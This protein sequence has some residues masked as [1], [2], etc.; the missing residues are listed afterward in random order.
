MP[1]NIVDF[2]WSGLISSN[3]ALGNTS[4]VTGT[5]YQVLPRIEGPLEPVTWNSYMHTIHARMAIMLL[6][7][8]IMQITHI[9]HIML[10]RWK[11]GADVITRTSRF[12]LPEVC[13]IH[14]VIQDSEP[15]SW[16]SMRWLTHSAVSLLC[17]PAAS[18]RWSIPA[19]TESDEPGAVPT[20]FRNAFKCINQQQS[21]LLICIAQEQNAHL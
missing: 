9:M 5:W 2:G 14:F 20:L 6:L 10:V 13:H 3:H 11:I 18:W 15:S 19:G 16:A 7:M 8:Q 21:I 12:R 17:Y 1:V 4:Y